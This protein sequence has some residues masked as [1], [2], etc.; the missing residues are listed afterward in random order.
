MMIQR[1]TQR[2]QFPFENFD[3]HE[4]IARSGTYTLVFN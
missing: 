2:L 4:E 1:T 3:A